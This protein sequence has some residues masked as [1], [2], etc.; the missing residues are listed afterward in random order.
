MDYRLEFSKWWLSEFQTIKFPSQGTI[1]DYFIDP[2]SK[3]FTLWSEKVP[4]FDLNPDVPLQVGIL[5]RLSVVMRFICLLLCGL[6]L[7]GIRQAPSMFLLH[8]ME[9]LAGLQVP[10]LF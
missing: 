7:G 3:R 4:E 8:P 5:H 6:P 2:E 9:T 1:F 10:T